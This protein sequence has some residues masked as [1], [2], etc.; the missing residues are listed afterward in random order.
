M[1]E[2]ERDI[3]IVV[4]R[5][6]VGKTYQLVKECI[7]AALG[8]KV[9]LVYPMKVCIFDCNVISGSYKQFKTIDF[10]SNGKTSA[11]RCKKVKEW[12]LPDVRRVVNYQKN[13]ELMSLDQMNDTALDLMEHFSQ[14]MLCLEDMN[15]YLQSAAQKRFL[16]E[17][18]R[19]RHKGVDLVMVVQ[20][21]GVIAPKMWANC[22]VLRMHKTFDNVDAIKDKVPDQ[23]EMLKIAQL[24]VNKQYQIGNIRFFLYVNMRKGKIKGASKEAFMQACREYAILNPSDIHE[25]VKIEKIKYDQALNTFIQIKVRDYFI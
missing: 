6:G 3:V 22:S 15:V 23:Y 24:I 17:F 4:G 11:E 5:Q 25:M 19:V 7:Q 2:R 21:L 18:V 20:S 13:G 10:N 14:G 8:N 16:S 9:K 12:T 1:E